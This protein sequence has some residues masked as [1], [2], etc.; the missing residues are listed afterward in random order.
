MR[1][2]DPFAEVLP[3]GQVTETLGVSVSRAREP[4]SGTSWFRPFPRSMQ[5]HLPT[6]S[7]RMQALPVVADHFYCLSLKSNSVI[8]RSSLA[9][10]ALLYCIDRELVRASAA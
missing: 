9:A 4:S 3:C 8:A 1:D 2:Y 6:N 7:N 5:N 10:S